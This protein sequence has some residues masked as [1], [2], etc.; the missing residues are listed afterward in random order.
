MIIS[1]AGQCWHRSVAPLFPLFLP[2]LA[3]NFMHVE[4]F[5]LTKSLARQGLQYPILFSLAIVGI[6]E[7]IAPIIVPLMG[8]LSVL[9]HNKVKVWSINYWTRDGNGLDLIQDPRD[10]NLIGSDFDIDVRIQNGSGA[11][12]DLS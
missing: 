10:P 11:N 7:K 3:R 1:L 2:R 9:G 8:P 4:L 12:M 6:I 5:G